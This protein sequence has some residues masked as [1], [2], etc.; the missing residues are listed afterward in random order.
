MMTERHVELWLEGQAT[1]NEQLS[2]VMLD[3]VRALERANARIDALNERVS[4]MEG[5]A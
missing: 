4:E 3:L 5:A 2:S 1:V